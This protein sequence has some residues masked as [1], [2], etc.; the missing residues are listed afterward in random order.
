MAAPGRDLP[1]RRGPL[2][3]NLRMRRQILEGKYIA[4]RQ[5]DD[6]V[7]IRRSRKLAERAQYRINSSAAVV[8]HH[9]HKRAP[10]QCAATEQRSALR[11]RESP[12]TRIRP[13]LSR[14]WEAHA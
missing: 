8:G 3:L 13:A 14:R 9:Q 5:V 7:W 10:Q 1:Q 6:R 2:F 11:R 4:R 12:V